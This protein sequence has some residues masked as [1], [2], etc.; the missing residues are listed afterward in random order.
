MRQA[1]G[2]FDNPIRNFKDFLVI[3]DKITKIQFFNFFKENLTV[4]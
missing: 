3:K 2:I 1:N 4:F